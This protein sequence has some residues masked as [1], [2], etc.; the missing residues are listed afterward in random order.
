MKRK[1]MRA[2]PVHFGQAVLDTLAKSPGGK[3]KVIDSKFPEYLV[4]DPS[5]RINKTDLEKLLKKSYKTYASFSWKNIR[6]AEHKPKYGDE[7]LV[8][9]SIH[10]L[11]KPDCSFVVYETR[12]VFVVEFIYKNPNETQE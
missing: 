10:K 3:F 5:T 2:D 4:L 9:A 6:T 11:D 8:H 1:K 7:Q 12:N